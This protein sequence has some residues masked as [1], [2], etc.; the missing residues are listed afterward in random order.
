MLNSA[1]GFY[2]SRKPSNQKECG[3]G[4]SCS[5]TLENAYRNFRSA[6]QDPLRA[7]FNA[8]DVT[9][10]Q[11]RSS[12]EKSKLNADLIVIF[13]IIAVILGLSVSE[14]PLSNA[15]VVSHQQGGDPVDI[16]VTGFASKAKLRKK[17]LDIAARGALPGSTT[18]YS[19]NG[20]NH[21]IKHK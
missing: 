13:G 20:V 9:T 16:T 5:G 18:Y 7:F 1:V 2:R 11:Y 3:C 14:C 17:A 6:S 4:H 10:A 19:A 8:M 21:E 15:A 12:K